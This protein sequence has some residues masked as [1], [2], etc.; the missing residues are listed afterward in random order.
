MFSLKP[1]NTFKIDAAARAF[2]SIASI[3][4]LLAVPLNERTNA[5]ILGGGSNTLFTHKQIGTVLHVANK[6]INV[7]VNDS[8]VTLDAAAGEIWNDV[9][10]FAAG[11]NWWGLEYLVDIPGTAGGAAVQ[12]IG[13][14]GSEFK[15]VAMSID[16]IDL[17]SG[18]KFTI[19]A[20]DCGYGY[21]SSIFK[22]HP[23]WL[24]WNVRLQL[25]L[26]RRERTAGGSRSFDGNT[27]QEISLQISA[28]R[29]SKLPPLE[30]YGSAGSFFKNP[31]ITAA[32]FNDIHAQYPDLNGYPA[33][34]I[35]ISAGWLIEKCGWKGYRE[36]DAGVYE[37][38][39]LVLINFGNAS[40]KQ[41]MELAQ[42]IILSV[43][44]K[45]GITLS[46]EVVVR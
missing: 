40:G 28:L 23:Q 43:K 38:Q 5:Y 9:V 6:G 2:Y 36:G 4:D 42:K 29:S 39:A 16:A 13:A 27:P 18:E 19:A 31:V 14:Y 21:R 46:P 7:I 11:N 37:K 1:Y 12:N 32:Q 34:D 17:L 15:D 25:N 44:E 33:G 3:E 22:K 30:L 8:S 10:G 35:K 41:I 20:K 24:V 45:F 26:N